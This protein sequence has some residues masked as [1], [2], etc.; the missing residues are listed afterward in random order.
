LSCLA[1]V[2]STSERAEAELRE[3]ARADLNLRPLGSRR[4]PRPER[5]LRVVALEDVRDAVARLDRFVLSEF[6]AEIGCTRQQARRQLERV[7][8]LWQLDGFVAGVPRYCYVAPP[9]DVSPAPVA[10]PADVSPAPAR[11]TPRAGDMR[12]KR[13]QLASRP[14]VG[15]IACTDLRPIVSQ[16]L[17]NGWHLEHRKGAKH[18]LRLVREGRQ[19][20][21]LPSTPRNPS[22]AARQLRRQLAS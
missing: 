20:I 19:A 8:D 18:P 17:Q 13:G 7:N 1:D 5:Q 9:A 21:G 15:M 6:A 2:R 3:A 10:P 4:P 12:A 16:A 14:L 11:G 22:E